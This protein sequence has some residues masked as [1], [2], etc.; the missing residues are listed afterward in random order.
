[1]EKLMFR[2]ALA[3]FT[4]TPLA[5]SVIVVT[6]PLY[7][8]PVTGIAD[9]Y[10]RPPLTVGT[11]TYTIPTGDSILSA[12]VAGTFGNFSGGFLNSTAPV[13]LHLAGET[14]ATCANTD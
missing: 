12:A 4:A 3:L 8:G 10:P 14:V 13:S 6:L 9:P 7:D 1:M 5:A 11:F 2:F